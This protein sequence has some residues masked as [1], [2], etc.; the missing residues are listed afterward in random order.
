[1]AEVMIGSARGDERGGAHGGAAGDQTGREVS[2]QP[3]YRHP[4]GWRVLRCA[5]E[6]RAKR[7]ARAMRAACDNDRIGYDQYQR[8]TLYNAAAAFG[9]DPALVR[10]P[11][12]TD[13]SALVRVC[14]AYAGIDTCNFNTETEAKTLLD[15]G[16]FVELTG[17][18]FT[19]WPD[20]L[21]EGDVLVTAVRGHTAVVLNDGPQ[22]CGAA[23][24]KHALGSRTLRNGVRGD[25]VRDLQTAL[26][27]LGYSCGPWGADGDFGD[28]TELAVRALQRSA[29]IGEDGV[30][31]PKTLAA[32]NDALAAA[33]S[34]KGA[35]DTV[36]IAGGSCWIR[37]AP[38][39]DAKRLGVA[40]EGDRLPYL[41]E[42]SENGWLRVAL[43]EKRGWVSGKY[44]RAA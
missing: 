41:G 9:F 23:P 10:E 42:T 27:G 35:G 37:E 33:E 28:A 26:I 24:V 36:L 21:R 34:E 4:K 5:D 14:L 16:E 11:V 31:G 39:A 19:D 3:W 43:G 17:S 40:K 30:F 8:L 12:E 7:I 13:C 20:A 38:C 1:M 32:L 44:G 18:L 22:A 29:N 6:D 15:T 25:D 2:M